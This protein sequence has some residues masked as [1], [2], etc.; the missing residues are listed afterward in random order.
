MIV[1]RLE[2]IKGLFEI[3]PGS[4]RFNQNIENN[5]MQRSVALA[6]IC[7]PAKTR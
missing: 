3:T 7:A 5:P 1:V 6:G 2:S 4:R